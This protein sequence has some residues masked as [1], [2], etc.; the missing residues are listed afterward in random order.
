MDFHCAACAMPA[1]S[2]AIAGPRVAFCDAIRRLYALTSGC[3][4]QDQTESADSSRLAGGSP[5]L[6]TG[7]AAQDLPTVGASQTAS[8]NRDL[9]AL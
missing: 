6:R 5:L 1:H 8:L 3:R 7:A 9:N 2:Q 4:V